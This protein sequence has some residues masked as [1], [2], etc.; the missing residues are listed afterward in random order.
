[1]Q[2][3]GIATLFLYSPAALVGN[4]MNTWELERNVSDNS[5]VYQTFVLG[6]HAFSETKCNWLNTCLKFIWLLNIQI[7]GQHARQ[8]LGLLQMRGTDVL[9]KWYRRDHI[10]YVRVVHISF[11]FTCW[12]TSKWYRPFYKSFLRQNLMSFAGKN[13]SGFIQNGR[14]FF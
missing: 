12:W 7:I 14:R 3:P 8:Y 5:T 6:N 2:K 11:R 1:M 9:T 13:V 10:I 4:N